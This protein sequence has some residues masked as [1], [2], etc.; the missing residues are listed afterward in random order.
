MR[1]V[2][3]MCSFWQKFRLNLEIKNDLKL[4]LDQ[5]LKVKNVFS[6]CLTVLQLNKYSKHHDLMTFQE[7]SWLKK[8]VPPCPIV[9]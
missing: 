7:I 3:V 1:F 8:S 5:V 4:T 6:N 9:S 2:H